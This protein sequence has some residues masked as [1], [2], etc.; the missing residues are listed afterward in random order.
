M[1]EPEPHE[2]KLII[3]PCPNC[4][5]NFSITL[6]GHRVVELESADGVHIFDLIDAVCDSCGF[7][8]G[9]RVPD[10]KPLLDHL[11]ASENG[12]EVENC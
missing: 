9:R 7:V 11:Q 4:N 8:F 3:R 6:L 12:K 5:E 10:S 2:S 1:T